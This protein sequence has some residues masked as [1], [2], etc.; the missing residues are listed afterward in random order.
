MTLNEKLVTLFIPVYSQGHAIEEL[1]RQIHASSSEWLDI[2]VVA[3]GCPPDVLAALKR[4][5]VPLLELTQNAG[6]GGAIQRAATTARTPYV[7]WIPG[8]LKISISDFEE[9]LRRLMAEGPTFRAAK[10]IRIGRSRGD[11]WKTRV[12]STTQSVLAR[13][14]LRDAGAPPTIMARDLVSLIAGGPSDYGFDHW[15]LWRL[16]TN[17]IEVRRFPIRYVPHPSV[18]STWNRGNGA[19]LRMFV[20]LNREV[21][22]W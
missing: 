8:N 5:G 20:H 13:K 18:P 11:L 16:L 9:N 15:V 19:L 3:N 4:S 6:Y 17:N 12:L 22:K 21:L 14:M 2:K 1:A 7:A 10:G